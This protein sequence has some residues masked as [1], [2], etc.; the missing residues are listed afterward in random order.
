MDNVLFFSEDGSTV[1]GCD[2]TYSGGIVIPEGV[3]SL[4]YHAFMDN[5]NLNSISLPSS[6]ETIGQ[7]TFRRCFGLSYIK[8]GIKVREIGKGAFAET[9]VYIDV[10][11]DNPN[12]SSING[13]LFDKRKS[14]LLHYFCSSPICGDDL[15]NTLEAIG[16]WA[17]SGINL[18][19]IV[20]LPSTIRFIGY[21]AFSNCA[22][23][24]EIY[25]PQ[26]LIRFYH[27]QWHNPSEDIYW[28][29]SY[30]FENCYALEKVVINDKL[31]TIPPYTFSGCSSL[32]AISIPVNVEEIAS[33]AFLRCKGLEEVVIMNANINIS[34]VA[35]EY[36]HDGWWK[37]IK[38]NNIKICLDAFD[39]CS[40]VKKITIPNFNGNML[41]TIFQPLKNLI[42]IKDEGGKEIPVDTVKCSKA[43]DF[44]LYSM[45]YHNMGMNITKVRGECTAPKTYKEPIKESGFEIN[46]LYTSEQ[47]VSVILR[48]D[49]LH[50][51]G[52]GLVLGW[53]DYRAIDVD[54]FGKFYDANIPQHMNSVIDIFLRTLGL[55][56]DYQWIVKSGSQK[57]FHIIIKV[58]DFGETDDEYIAYAYSAVRDFE[59]I[60]FRFKDHLMLPPSIHASGHT[61]SFYHNRMPSSIPSYVK[62]SSINQL[63]EDYCGGNCYSK[64]KWNGRELELVEFVKAKSTS[65]HN[66]T[67]EEYGEDSMQWLEACDSPHCYNSLAIRY[68]MGKSVQVDSMKAYE[69]FLKANNSQAFFNLAS[70]ISIG[71]FQG[72][73]Q[74]VNGYLEKID[75]H[76]LNWDKEYD[77]YDYDEMSLPQ[78]KIAYIRRNAIFYLQH[79]NKNLYLFFDT[80]TT[81]VPIDYKAPSSD[82]GNWPRMVQ[83]AWILEDENGTIIDSDNLIIIPDGFIIPDEAVNVHGITTQ[84][85]QND[86]VP[87]VNAIRE[88]QANMDVATYIVGHNIEFDKKI[89]GAEMI[90]LGREDIMDTKKSLCTMQSSIDFCKIPGKNGYKYPKL[91][92]L[93][94]KLFGSEFDNAHDAMSDIKAT[95]KCFWELR[96]H[97]LI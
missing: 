55:P 72:T 3:I 80:E 18:L 56:S 59:R 21:K 94:K 7:E 68:A 10:D 39:G 41:F 66:G 90:R 50:V 74:D 93:Y 5:I 53:N 1:I 46:K 23:L 44:R 27:S 45:F 14:E 60:E 83:L 76:Q 40:N 12:Y 4:R 49:W 19:R 35:Y 31:K 20:K 15:P 77:G 92:E 24:K 86:G 16:N 43:I 82:A 63:L 25:L 2:K 91:Q 17:F 47:D 51:S 42:C 34:L 38:K 30:T 32:K 13:S 70:L 33:K 57:G 84:K 26:N 95:E 48:E 11:E 61:Y 81:G 71:Y 52:I 54:N 58:K 73:I 6:V 65:S 9:N 36:K 8:I 85:A 22:N 97:K 37:N 96:R 87:L 78:N 28:Y 89:V 69:L 88:F 64:Y 67:I 62:I 79:K 75:I 29:A